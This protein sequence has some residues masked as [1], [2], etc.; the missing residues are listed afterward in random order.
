MRT[1]C[2]LWGP[3]LLA[4]GILLFAFTGSF[5][6]QQGEGGG[7][8]DKKLSAILKDVINR[9]AD[10]YNLQR[11]YAGCYRLFQGALLTVRPMLDQHPDLQ[12]TIDASLQNA[13]AIP[14]AWQ[15]AFALREA[16]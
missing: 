14:I 7:D 8:A 12:K 13:E 15:R 2:C 5:R 3:P 9:G 1:R 4:A 6:A 16:L 11:D 10:I